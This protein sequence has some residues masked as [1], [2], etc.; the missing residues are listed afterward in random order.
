MV[1]FF[2]EPFLLVLF[3]ECDEIGTLAVGLDDLPERPPAVVSCIQVSAGLHEKRE[4]SLEIIDSHAPV[5]P[6]QY[7]E[8]GIV[9]IWLDIQERFDAFVVPY[10]VGHLW[11]AWPCHLSLENPVIKS[12]AFYPSWK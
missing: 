5:G 8:I 9:A 1:N 2:H 12:A 4:E 3:A 6:Q 7:V 11:L 10:L